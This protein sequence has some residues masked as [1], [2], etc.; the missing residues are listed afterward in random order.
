MSDFTDSIDTKLEAHGKSWLGS[1][2]WEARLARIAV[3]MSVIA[4]IFSV[5]AIVM[6]AKAQDEFPEG[7]NAPARE[8]IYNY[9]YPSL[10]APSYTIVCSSGECRPVVF[11]PFGQSG[12]VHPQSPYP[13][14]TGPNYGGG[15]D[16]NKFGG[17]KLSN[18]SRRTRYSEGH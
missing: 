15:A 2:V 14:Y 3:I 4:L 10:P 12:P 18:E 8:D 7:D 16:Y 17:R 9:Y 11:G 5:F 6:V 13:V 1:W